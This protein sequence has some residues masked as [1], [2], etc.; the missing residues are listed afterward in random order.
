M[1]NQKILITIG[2]LIGWQF[3]EKL[4]TL[5]LKQRFQEFK[6]QCQEVKAQGY[7]LSEAL[8]P[9]KEAKKAYKQGNYRKANELLDETFFTLKKISSKP[10]V[11]PSAPTKEGFVTVCGSRFCLNGKRYRFVGANVHWRFLSFPHDEIDR[12]FEEASK[13]GIEVIRVWLWDPQSY[14]EVGFE[15]IDYM[16]ESARRHN[17]KLIIALA[18]HGGIVRYRIRAH[19]ELKGEDPRKVRKGFFE[20]KE[21][22]ILYKNFVHN[23]ITRTNSIN[24][25]QYKEDP[26]IFAWELMNEPDCAS[27]PSI[28]V[29]TKWIEETSN[30]IRGID[31][32]HMIATGCA[33]MKDPNIFV[34]LHTAPNIS[35]FT[36][37]FYPGHGTKKYAIAKSRLRGK[38]IKGE[39]KEITPKE[40]REMISNLISI[41]KKIGK[42]IVME[43]Y[44]TSRRW[45]LD[46]KVWY[47]LMLD[48]F[49]SKDGDGT[50][51]WTFSA[52]SNL[53]EEELE[54]ENGISL[55]PDDAELREIIE[56]KAKEIE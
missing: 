51:F 29:L 37:H 43:E 2:I 28:D 46:R 10:A 41:S 38:K 1:M 15:D 6:T 39:I 53:T 40:A 44:G 14:P 36:F 21:A 18:S 31:K 20:D 34:K 5:A 49:Y 19:P 25:V 42:P 33:H 48:E 47:S 17:I 27:P 23:L 22:N 54:R 35:F 8:R 16:L 24:G 26:T 55:H 30:Y 9:Y 4:D 12:T 3:Q 56:E 13:L 52:R 11:P 7:D 50:A 45:G 32:N